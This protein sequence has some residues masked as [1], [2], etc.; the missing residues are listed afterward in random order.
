MRITTLG[1]AGAVLAA[2]GCGSPNSSTGVSEAPLAESQ[3]AVTDSAS[4]AKVDSIPTAQAQVVVNG[5]PGAGAIAQVQYWH[6]GSPFHDNATMAAFTTPGHILNNARLFVASTSNFGAPL[7][8]TNEAPGSVLS[9]DTAVGGATIPP[10]FAA[11]GDQ[12]SAF[13]GT[14]RVYSANSP[15]YLNSVHEPQAATANLVAV[16]LTTGISSNNGHG[17]PWFSNAPAGA[18]G[19]GTITVIDPDGAP[20]AGAP[21]ATAGGVFAGDLTN[22][23][24]ATTHGLT[25]AALGTAIMTKSP[26]ASGKAVF[27]SV[28]A[29][30]SVVQIHVQ[31]GVDGMAPAGTVTPDPRVDVE[32]AEST[33]PWAIA[34][35]GIAFNWAPTRIV[36]VADPYRN[37][38][39]ALDLSDDGV[40]FSE[41]TR[42]LQSDAFNLPIDIAAVIP[43]TEADNF[44]SNTTLGVGSDLYVLNRGDNSIVRI[45]QGGKVVAVRKISAPV[46][47]FRVNGIATSGNGKTIYVSAQTPGHGGVVLSLDAFGENQTMANLLASAGNGNIYDIGSVMFSHDFGVNEGVG[48]LFNAQSCAGCHNDPVLGGMGLGVNTHDFRVGRMVHGDFQALKSPVTRQHS[49]EE[50]GGECDLPTGIPDN[51]QI[52]SLR[53]TPTLIGTALIDDVAESAIINAMNAEPAAV[54]GHPNYLDD[55][56]IGRFGWKAHVATLVE[57]M[58]AAFRDEQGLTNPLHPKDLENGCG[59]NKNGEEVSGTALVATAAFLNQVDPPVPAL[60]CLGSAG[61]Q[62]FA[63]VGCASCHTPSMAGPGRTVNLYSDLL[64]HDMGNGLADGV[65]QASASGNEFR[66]TPLWKIS[67][68]AAFLHDGSATSISDAIA[69]H[70]GQAA[71]SAA[72]YQALSASDKQA[73]LDF[74]G[75]I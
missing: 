70:G 57:F 71:N 36:Y 23:N 41:T 33:N 61:A 4:A 74:L 49:I 48:P 73:V 35:Y 7:A 24:A 8:R 43:E 67:E 60:S 19:Y 56:R 66:T 16:S 17:R 32:T 59:A 64:L 6:R 1:L 40:K 10:S 52:V 21:D 2:A 14:V 44:S 11:A 30:G 55:G 22:R 42:Y 37:R 72:A 45:T 75:C 68:R 47:G 51:A 9:I 20:L 13:G 69:R 18:T 58:G 12:A 62:K 54:R 27:A 53:G 50:L 65:V 31:K 25:Y 29:D 39:A 34:R 26:D 46:P 28:L 38:I 63:E 3:Q 15:A 5:I